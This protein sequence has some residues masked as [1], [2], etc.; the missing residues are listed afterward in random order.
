M[1]EGA[2]FLELTESEVKELVKAVGVVKRIM[3]LQQEMI[4]KMKSS[5][6]VGNYLLEY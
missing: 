6:E 5:N 3:R 2:T 1:L 4:Q